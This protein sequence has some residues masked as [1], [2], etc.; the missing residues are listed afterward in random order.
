MGAE[1]ALRIPHLTPRPL[2][3]PALH[4]GLAAA[5]RSSAPRN[6]AFAP[7]RGEGRFV[8]EWREFKSP[9]F[10]QMRALLKQPLIFDGRNLFDP[11]LVHSLGIEY[12]AIGRGEAPREV[13][14]ER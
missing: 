8:T 2:P 12:H 14:L 10:E 5:A 3:R 9:D 4:R 7:A 11:A 6:P 1:H 13:A